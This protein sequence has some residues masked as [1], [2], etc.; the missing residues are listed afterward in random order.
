MTSMDRQH[1]PSTSLTSPSSSRRPG[2]TEPQSSPLPSIKLFRPAVPTFAHEIKT[3]Q[4]R[5][6]PDHAIPEDNDELDSYEERRKVASGSKEWRCRWKTCEISF[7]AQPELI[8]HL[9]NGNLSS[10][11]IR[12][13]QLNG[14]CQI[15]SD[16]GKRIMLA[17]GR[18]VQE[19]VKSKRRDIH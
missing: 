9:H 14:S 6:S 10:I 17:N 13:I 8:Y 16:Q 1:S 12:R 11:F 18:N 4:R 2:G 19:E 7:G 5:S 3:E 15:T